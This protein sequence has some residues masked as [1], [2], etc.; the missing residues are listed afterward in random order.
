MKSSKKLG[1]SYCQFVLNY[2]L[3]CFEYWT[4]GYPA[5]TVDSAE[6]PP[7]STVAQKPP[8]LF[9]DETTRVSVLEGKDKSPASCCCIDW[10]KTVYWTAVCRIV[11]YT[12]HFRYNE[13]QLLYVSSQLFVTGDMCCSFLCINVAWSEYFYFIF[14]FPFPSPSTLG[15][16]FGKPNPCDCYCTCTGPFAPRL[17]LNLPLCIKKENKRNIYYRL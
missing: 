12:A 14:T 17:W 7:F 10:W 2:L 1:Y 5:L 13:A 11:L 3:S 4:I 8:C 6:L 16:V 15:I 9:W